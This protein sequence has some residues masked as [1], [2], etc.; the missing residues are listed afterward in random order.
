M[1]PIR[2]SHTGIKLPFNIKKQDT[3]TKWSQQLVLRPAWLVF[4]KMTQAAGK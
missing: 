1:F 3:Y 2:C 4:E